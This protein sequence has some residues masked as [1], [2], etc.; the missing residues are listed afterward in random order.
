MN[1]RLIIGICL[2]AAA[3]TVRGHDFGPSVTWNR[4]ISRLFF[5]RCASCHHE[6]GD[7]F[8]LTSYRDAQPRAVAIR[9]AVLARRM[10]PWGA[11]KGFGDF[12]N[13]ESLTQEQI[14]LVAGWVVGGMNRGNN[15][16]ALPPLPRFEARA[17]FKVPPEGM[18]VGG[19]TTLTH[20]VRIGGVWPERVAAENSIQV[21][22]VL[23][24]G[25]VKPLVWFY[26]Y[27]DRYQ[28][29]FLFRKPL[30]LPAGTQI[31]GVQSPA[32]IV[33]LPFAADGT[34]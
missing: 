10:P 14:E 29:P 33:L 22:A 6:G 3:V 8:P 7:T 17:S 32:S 13:D 24:G 27:R 28:H 11:V 31:R 1:T 16:N 21:T 19:P 9:D 4:E 26:E 30:D 20:A 15:P 12:R 18:R 25:A 34:R 2:C 23:P 5:E